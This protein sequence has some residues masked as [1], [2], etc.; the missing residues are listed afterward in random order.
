MIMGRPSKMLLYSHA[1]C[2]VTNGAVPLTALDAQQLQYK[3]VQSHAGF[4]VTKRVTNTAASCA[5]H[6]S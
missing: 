2:F 6:R 5:P 1:G 3:L 4:Y